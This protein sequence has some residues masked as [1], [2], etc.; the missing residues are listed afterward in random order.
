MSYLQRKFADLLKKPT[1]LYQLSSYDENKPLKVV[2]G[3]GYTSFS[4]WI[5]TDIETLN[6]LK[7]DDWRQY[8]RESS[9]SRILAEHVW[10]HFTEADGKTAFVN[11][12]TFLKPGGFLRV[13]VPDGFHPDEE[14]INKVKPGGTGE[15]ADDHKILYNYRLMTEFLEGIG[16]KVRLV[17]YFDEQGKFHKNDWLPED[18]LIRRSADHDQ[19]N[20]GGKLVYTSL[21]VDAI[22][23]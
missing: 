6:I 10:E 9:I 19:R 7:A 12:H 1:S 17:E 20:Q 16:Y 21:I 18:G 2:I 4:G 5:H 8:F 11:C 22:K 14:Y 13:A 3:S 15:G 23:Q